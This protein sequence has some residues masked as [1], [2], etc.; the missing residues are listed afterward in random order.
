M[1]LDPSLTP[2]YT[3][4]NSKEI[5]DLNV[6]AKTIKLLE[7]KTLGKIYGLSKDFLDMTLFYY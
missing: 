5:T 1:N 6:G 4:V 2:T 3:K 7:K